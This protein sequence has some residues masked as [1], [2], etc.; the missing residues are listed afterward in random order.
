MILIKTFTLYNVN[1]SKMTDYTCETCT[2]SFKRKYNYEQHIEKKIQSINKKGLTACIG[3]I[4][5]LNT[6]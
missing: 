5:Q 1:L 3:Q 2:K 4:L 6:L